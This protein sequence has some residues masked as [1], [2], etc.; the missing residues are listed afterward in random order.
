MK[1]CVQGFKDASIYEFME[2]HREVYFKIGK[3][4]EERIKYSISND[5][6]E[7]KGQDTNQ[8]E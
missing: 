4:I 6:E 1:K 2:V 5:K 3:K 7:R 8:M